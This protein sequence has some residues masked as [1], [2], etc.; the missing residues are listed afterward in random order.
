MERCDEMTQHQELTPCSAVSFRALLSPYGY[1]HSTQA[2]GETGQRYL[3][4]LSVQLPVNV[5]LFQ[6]KKVKKETTEPILK[7]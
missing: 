5:Q 2:I 4:V 6:N 3:W 1:L 7:P